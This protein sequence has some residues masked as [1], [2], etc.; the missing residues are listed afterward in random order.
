MANPWFRLYTEI[1][2]DEKMRLLAFED[3]WHF[4]AI[5]CCKN[6]GMLDSGDAPAMLMRKL[7]V[8]LGLQLRE[9]EAVLLRLSEVGLIYSDTAQPLAWD[10]RQ[11]QSDSSTSRVK[12]YRERMKQRGNVSVTAQD[13]DTDTDTNTE[14]RKSTVQPAAARSRFE[15]FWAAYPNKK[16]RQDAE[17]RWKRDKLDAMADSIIDHVRLMQSEDDG[18]RRGYVPMGSTYLN[19]SRWTDVPQQA[20]RERSQQAAPSKGMQAIMNLQA[21]KNE[22]VDANGD[23]NGIPAAHLPWARQ[24]AGNGSDGRNGV[25]LDV[26]ANAQPRLGSGAGCST[27][28]QD[29]L[30]HDG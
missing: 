21:S 30:D 11:F 2:D 18:W 28:P 10:E 7:G 24:T 15:E 14:K 22:R 8:K 25:G 20:P 19:Q 6:S 1:V 23:R 5:L 16:G 12:A 9:L 29:V 3:R 27:F 17:K 26:R 4:V 13:T